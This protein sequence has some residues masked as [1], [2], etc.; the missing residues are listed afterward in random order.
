MSFILSAFAD[1]AAS[2]LDEQILAMKQN[3]IRF[4]EIRGVDGINIADITPQKAVE[5]RKKTDD[6]SLGIWS[7]GSPFGKIG[8]NEEFEPHLESFK[9]SIE[10]AHILGAKNIRIF[11]FYGA[12]SIS[13]V[14]SRLEKFIEAAKGS[15]I[16]LCHENEKAIYGDT[17]PKCLE[18]HKALPELKAVFDPANFI[19]CGQNVKDA[20][21]M[22]SPYV[23]YMHIK[24]ALADGSVVPAGKGI[25]NLEYLLG[26]YRGTV[27]TIEP[28]LSIFSGRDKLEATPDAFLGKFIYPDNMT[29][30][31][32]ATDT[33]KE[34]LNKI[35]R[36]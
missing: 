28:H 22:L 23:C 6:A 26:K 4:L 11:S 18:I 32:A 17:A 14:L 21:D 16:T 33:L 7:L 15:G 35:E 29:A 31:K 24:D 27:L 9:R 10:N 34:I 2:S 3:N 30:F 20:W 25:G 19:Q 12:D 36:T 5:I 1:E 8:I 13:P